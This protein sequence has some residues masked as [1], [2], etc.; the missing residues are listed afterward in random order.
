MLSKRQ[1]AQFSAKMRRI[2]AD[3]AVP[4]CFRGDLRKD[5]RPVPAL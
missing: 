3:Y 5:L 4:P 2:A 1:V